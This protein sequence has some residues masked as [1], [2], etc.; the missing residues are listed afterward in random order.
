[1]VQAAEQVALLSVLAVLELVLQILLLALLLLMLLVV[2]DI[3]LALLE[4]PTLEMVAAH[5]ERLALVVQ[6][7]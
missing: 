6:A 5:L 2:L 1:V 7:T 3:Y 4:Q